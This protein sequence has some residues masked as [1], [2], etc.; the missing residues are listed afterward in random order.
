SNWLMTDSSVLDNL[1]LGGTIDYQAPYGAFVPKTLTVT[2]LVGN[3]GTIT[4]YNLFDCNTALI[5]SLGLDG[6]TAT[7]NTNIA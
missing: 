1:T 7:G 4:L 2:Y 6:G 5:D 3:G